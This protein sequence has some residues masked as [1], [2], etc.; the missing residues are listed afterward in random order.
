MKTITITRDRVL[1]E[2]REVVSFTIAGKPKTGKTE[3]AV[4]LSMGLAMKHPMIPVLLRDQDATTEYKIIDGVLVVKKL[5]FPFNDADF[6]EWVFDR[7]D[8][9]L[10]RVVQE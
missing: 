8:F 3:T 9:T 2:G 7:S 5:P 6:G 4:P 1:I 10:V